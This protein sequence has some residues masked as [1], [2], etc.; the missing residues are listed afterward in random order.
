MT[1]SMMYAPTAAAAAGFPWF[2]LVLGALAVAG[3]CCAAGWLAHYAHRR[4][5]PPTRYEHEPEQ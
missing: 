5:P 3:I 1:D 2:V 4:W